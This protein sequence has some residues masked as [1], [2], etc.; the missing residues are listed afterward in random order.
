[1]DYPTVRGRNVG[2]CVSVELE[3]GDD[4]WEIGDRYLSAKRGGGYDSYET[5]SRTELEDVERSAIWAVR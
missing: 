4:V 3:V 5:S 2:V 1:M